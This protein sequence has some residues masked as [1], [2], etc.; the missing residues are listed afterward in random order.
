MAAEAPRNPTAVA[1]SGLPTGLRGATRE[2][3]Q[4]QATIAPPTMKARSTVPSD[5]K[6]PTPSSPASA[7]PRSQVMRVPAAKPSRIWTP[8]ALPSARTMP[9]MRRGKPRTSCQ[10]VLGPTIASRV[11]RP[12]TI[13]V[14]ANQASPP[15]TGPTCWS[16]ARYARSSETPM[17]T[18][19]PRRTRGHVARIVAAA[20]DSLIRTARRH[21]APLMTGRGSSS[22]PTDPVAPDVTA[23]GVVPAAGRP[24]PRADPSARPKSAFPG[25]R[26]SWPPPRASAAP[27][28]SSSGGTVHPRSGPP[29][30]SPRLCEAGRTP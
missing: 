4:R 24:T 21:C 20:R 11:V 15:R 2:T 10:K 17:P 5:T 9:T 8:A 12:V 28:T 30:V 27:G 16:G 18:T 26:R 3:S 7:G 14:S 23:S 22:S 25:A 13:A 29:R 6:S 19:S 1:S